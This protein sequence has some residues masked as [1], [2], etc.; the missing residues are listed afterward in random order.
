MYCASVVADML[1]LRQA[2]KHKQRL[3]KDVDDLV[4][5]HDTCGM[6]TQGAL[7]LMLH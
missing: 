1:R 5:A 2:V 6:P 3:G 7:Y 4:L